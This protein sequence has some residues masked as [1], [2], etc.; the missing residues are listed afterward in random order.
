MG[1]SKCC[2]SMSRAGGHASVFASTGM[3]EHV[4]A[5]FTACMRACMRAQV[6]E[7]V[8]GSQR[9]DDLELLMRR[10]TEAGM[11]LAAYEG[12]LDIRRYGNVPHSG[13]WGWGG[14][15]YTHVCGGGCSQAAPFVSL[16]LRMHAPLALGSAL[17]RKGW[18]Y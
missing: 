1:W 16:L 13:G 18:A 3:P 10:L 5:C 11:D 4:R 12:Y 15:E 9:E 6:G 8:G 17:Q 7:L 14:G 2:N